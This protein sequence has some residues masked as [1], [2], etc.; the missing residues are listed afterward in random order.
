MKSVTDILIAIVF[1]IFLFLI[2]IMPFFILYLFSD[3]MFIV[4]FY[5]IGYRKKVML[6][7]LRETFPD[8]P[9]KEIH[10]L[11][12]KSYRNLTD[13]LIEG[14]KSFS[15]TRKQIRKRHHVVNPQILDSYFLNGQS[16]I[17][18]TGHYCNWEWG[19]LS[20]GL[21]I[22]HKAIAF[23]KPLSN[24]Y[25]DRFVRFNR[26][27]FGTTL[28]SIKETS[29]NFE[30]YIKAPAAFLMAADQSPTN[31]E[32]CFWIRFLGRD[33]A[34]LHGPA[35]HAKLNNIPVFYVDVQRLRRG[36]YQVEISLL[37][38]GVNMLEASEI[39]RLYAQKLENVILRKPENWLWSHRRWKHQRQ[40]S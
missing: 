36:F 16:V 10:I 26:A 14:I 5:A 35:K 25:I 34:F 8:K 11:L 39:T 21:F 22:R 32:Q 19:S 9:E 6:K 20:A 29:I 33:T 40:Q 30:R 4:L 12:R 28:A 17:A 38:D 23:Y 15:M 3:F 27:R 18:V 1:F 2:G 13:I 24:P 31:L 37:T 7:N